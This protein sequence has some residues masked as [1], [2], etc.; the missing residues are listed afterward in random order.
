M[1]RTEVRYAMPWYQVRCRHAVIKAQVSRPAASRVTTAKSRR[2]RPIK[3][4]SGRVNSKRISESG[5]MATLR[6]PRGLGRTSLALA[7]VG[8]KLGLPPQSN[9]VFVTTIHGVRVRLPASPGRSY[10]NRAG[11]CRVHGGAAG[12]RGL[13]IVGAVIVTGRATATSTAAG[14]LLPL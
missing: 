5:V 13:A 8:S 9:V 6:G 11:G 4:L 1:G 7:L 2:I 10:G 14:R 12:V 3:E